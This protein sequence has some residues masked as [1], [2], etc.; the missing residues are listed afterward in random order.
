MKKRSKNKLLIL[1]YIFVG[2]LFLYFIVGKYFDFDTYKNYTYRTVIL[3][4]IEYVG[5]SSTNRIKFSYLINNKQYT[6]A[7]RFKNDSTD[8]YKER[9][10]KKFLVK[11]N[12]K[13]WVNSIFFTYNLYID[14]PVPDS[15]KEAPPGGWKE[16]PEW[17]REI[18]ND[19]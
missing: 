4:K 10:G 2:I 8:F 17:A 13:E 7:Y 6:G 11:M 3:S 5:S 1:F 18:K 12:N 9:I 19:K 15:I 14:I 16:L